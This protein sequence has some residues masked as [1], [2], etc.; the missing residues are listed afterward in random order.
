VPLPVLLVVA[1]A[2]VELLEVRRRY[3]V[4]HRDIVYY[5]RIRVKIR[6]GGSAIPQGIPEPRRKR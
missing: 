5:G 1:A 4:L 6:S 2:P 3:Q